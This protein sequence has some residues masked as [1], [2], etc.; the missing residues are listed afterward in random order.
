MELMKRLTRK[1]LKKLIIINSTMAIR[2]LL[3][4]CPKPFVEP[5]SIIQQN[6]IS[7]WKKLPNSYLTTKVYID[8]F[9]LGEEIGVAEYA[10]LYNITHISDIKKNQYGTPLVDDI[11]KKIKQIGSD[12]QKQYPYDNVVCCYINADIIVFSEFI[13]NI[14]VFLQSRNNGI[15]KEQCRYV[16]NNRYLI[17]GERWDVD[18][19]K[20]FHIHKD[21]GTIDFDQDNCNEQL[22]EYARKSGRRHGCWGIDYF[23]FSPTTFGYI[24]PFAL[25]KFVWDRWLVGNIFRNDSITV[26]ITK[27][28]FVIHQ[29]CDWYQLCTG[30][31][32][33]NRKALFDTDEVKINQSF[34]YYEKDIFTGTQFE[35]VNNE[36]IT[37]LYKEHIPRKD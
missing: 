30:G 34:D 19:I 8:I 4:A 32:T 15:F 33:S 29:N 31:A 17:I 27:T 23:I 36:H 37:Y 24:Y 16:D 22:I 6:A 13:D 3:F 1:K 11:F 2:L 35:S 7:S 25:G 10:R 28:N 12:T 21:D 18:N 5:F 26:D 9:L 14:A 20:N